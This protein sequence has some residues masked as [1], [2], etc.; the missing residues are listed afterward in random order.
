MVRYPASSSDNW[1]EFKSRAERKETEEERRDL[2]VAM[3]RAKERLFIC[4]SGR[5]LAKTGADTRGKRKL[6]RAY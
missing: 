1:E 6:R 4:F 2:Y 5:R 3:T